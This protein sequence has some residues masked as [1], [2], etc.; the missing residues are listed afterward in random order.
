MSLH[1]YSSEDGLPIV[2]L[3][4][5]YA[6]AGAAQAEGRRGQT[7]SSKVRDA[8][9]RV[10]DIGFAFVALIFFLPLFML[11]PLLIKTTSPGPVLY[12]HK[13]IGRNGQHF[14][15]FKFR[16]MVTNGDEVLAELLSRSEE[17]KL[18]WNASRKLKHDPRVTW[19][20]HVLRKSSLDELPQF[21]NIICGD[22]SVVGPRPVI[23]DELR[24]YG[25]YADHYC[26]VR[27]GLTGLW[28][29]SG[30]SD[31][32]YEHRVRLDHAYVSSRTVI[33]DIVIIWKTIPAVICRR[34]TY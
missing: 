7:P 17:A 22:M 34:G 32:S 19:V 28:Q 9:K 14:Q 20:G 13:R 21:Y 4:S 31:V 5:V 15:C 29:V 27:P 24:L 11:I 12:G 26:S 6:P 1:S 18:E 3:S 23:D 16:T 33:G 10:L 2:Q 8:A 30:R 25:E